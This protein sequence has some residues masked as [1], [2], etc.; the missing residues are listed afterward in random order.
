[1]LLA[2]KSNVSEGNEVYF[3]PL[4]YLAQKKIRVLKVF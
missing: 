2:L 3:F 4:I 1:M